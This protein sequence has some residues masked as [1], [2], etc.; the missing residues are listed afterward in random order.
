MIKN[1]RSFIVQKMGQILCVKKVPFANPVTYVDSL[2]CQETLLELPI[3]RYKI[4][5]S[6]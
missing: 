4:M 6:N 1:L 3:L 2:N 5:Y